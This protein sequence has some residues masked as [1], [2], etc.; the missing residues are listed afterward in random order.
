MFWNFK[1]CKRLGVGGGGYDNQ[2]DAIQ[3]RLK[4]IQFLCK[5]LIHLEHVKTSIIHEKFRKSQKNSDNFFMSE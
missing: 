3:R 2:S 4:I 5:F 1:V